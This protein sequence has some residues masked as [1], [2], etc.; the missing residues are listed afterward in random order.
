MNP[1]KVSRIGKSTGIE[2]NLVA[3]RGWLGVGWGVLAKRYEVSL[4]DDKTVSKLY[5][6]NGCK[7]VC[8]Y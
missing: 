1:F 8:L 7:T 2:N 3:G 6:G 5:S 4:G